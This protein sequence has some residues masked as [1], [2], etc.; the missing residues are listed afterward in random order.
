MGTGNKGPVSIGSLSL[1]LPL[2]KATF[3]SQITVLRF[4]LSGGRTRIR[5]ELDP[6]AQYMMTTIGRCFGLN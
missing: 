2:E 4:N 3:A 5:L 6:L 1:D